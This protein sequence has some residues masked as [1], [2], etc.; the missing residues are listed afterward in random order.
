MV[1]KKYSAVLALYLPIAIFAFQTP[2]RGFIG[3]LYGRRLRAALTGK[4]S[5]LQGITNEDLQWWHSLSRNNTIDCSCGKFT[6]TNVTDRWTDEGITSLNEYSWSVSLVSPGQSYAFCGGSLVNDRYVLTAASCVDGSIADGVE[7]LIGT[8]PRAHFLTPMVE[9]D[10]L[11]LKMLIRKKVHRVI[12]H[13]Q[14]SKDH[15][16]NNI[17]LL[18]LYGPVPTYGNSDGVSPVCLPKP[19]QNFDSMNATSLVWRF[20]TDEEIIVPVKRTEVSSVVLSKEG[21]KSFNYSKEW[22]RMPD[23]MICAKTDVPESSHPF[24]D[25]YDCPGD[26]GSALVV[27]GNG[28]KVQIGIDSWTPCYGRPKGIGVYTRVAEF[29]PWIELHIS[30]DGRNCAY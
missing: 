9:P 6:E 23:T 11:N 8:W 16:D 17:A 10:E 20:H 7:V 5:D 1:S 18:R 24:F 26:A 22:E 29:I 14:Y 21:C 12:L 27:D 2:H 3:S 19:L 4:V 25:S 28:V 15:L 13:P 30:Q